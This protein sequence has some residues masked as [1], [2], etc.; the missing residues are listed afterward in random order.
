MFIEAKYNYF[1]G[2][3][4]YKKKADLE[5]GGGYKMGVVSL[6]NKHSGSTLVVMVALQG[7]VDGL[8]KWGLRARR[9]TK[10]Q[11]HRWAR[12]IYKTSYLV[13]KLQNVLIDDHISASE[14]LIMFYK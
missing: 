13:S 5:G 3:L 10:K 2:E 1:T 6:P 11:K 4:E 9:L 14:L 12:P 7:S 8:M